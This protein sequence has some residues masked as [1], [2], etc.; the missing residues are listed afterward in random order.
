MNSYKL[1]VVG[2]LVINIFQNTPAAD[3]R[4]KKA[5]HLDTEIVWE[6][7]RL[8]TSWFGNVHRIRLDP[9]G[10]PAEWVIVKA[11][12][13][14]DVKVD[15]ITVKFLDPNHDHPIRKSF[16]PYE[17]IRRGGEIRFKLPEPKRIISV[18][19]ISSGWSGSHLSDGF[20]VFLKKNTHRPPIESI[21]TGYFYGECIGGSQCQGY[22]RKQLQ[23]FS[24]D[25]EDVRN[26]KR[27]RFYSH[28]NIGSS[29]NA[30]VSVYVDD[31]KVAHHLNI[32]RRGSRHI[33]D[34]DRVF[35]RHITF[36]ATRHDEAVVQRIEV[37]YSLH[38]KELRRNH[39]YSRKHHKRHKD[40]GRREHDRPGRPH[41]RDGS[42]N[43]PRGPYP[44]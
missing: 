34:L 27:I 44:R 32:K 18:K 38:P 7:D 39:Y 25:L 12:K 23:S 10:V 29:H 20:R 31:E 30:K 13:Q 43:I 3:A 4:Q 15:Q 6:S 8:F 19:V 42:K 17:R 22:R 9:Y 28:D 21:Q 1:W 37:D 11:G 14:W 24:I 40:H 41:K 16:Y 5:P 2:W 35:G 33:I 26:I 36:E